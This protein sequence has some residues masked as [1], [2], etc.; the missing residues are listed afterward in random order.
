MT[1]RLKWRGSLLVPTALVSVALSAQIAEAQ[2]SGWGL[3]PSNSSLADDAAT[4]PE[5][6][7]GYAYGIDAGV[8]ETD[9][10]ALSPTNKVSQTIAIT[11]ADFNVDHR[12]RLFDVNAI[13]NFSYLEYLQHAYGNQL[14]G[15]FDGNADAAIVPGRLIW[16]LRDDFGQS[17]LDPYTPTTP[18]NVENINYVTTGPDLKVRFGGINFIDVSARYARAQY[19]TSPFNSNRLLGSVAL[20]RE[21][22]AGGSVSL[23]A[24]TERVMF[25]NTE[26][27]SDFERSSGFGRY[28]VHGTRTNFIGELGGT[29]VSQTS[30]L[31]LVPSNFVPGSNVTLAP[32]PITAANQSAGS[33]SLSGPMAKVELSRM[34]S[35]SAKVIFTAGR[36]LTD[37]SSSFSNQSTG[38]TGINSIS[39]AALTS[40]SYRVTYASAS[41]QFHRNRT[42]LAITGRWEKDIYPGLPN[43]D[44]TF[45]SVDFRVERRVTRALT[46]QFFGSYRKTDYP[47][48]ALASQLEGSTEYANGILG[49]ALTWR[50]GRGLEVRLRF[51]H[52][53]YSVSNG[54][55][56]YHETRAF[57]TVGYRPAQAADNL[58]EP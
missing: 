29:V 28:E 20:G 41:W 1:I 7:Q 15:R 49:A 54:N 37:A 45:P 10:V 26:V 17:A 6:V 30:A 16:V 36:D 40:D 34:T 19:Q 3:N 50:H 27:N 18:T 33:G 39:S 44:V 13:G 57:L 8:G 55:T 14:L 12:S 42:T 9:N 32:Q 11:D 35:A 58:L 56:G 25:D 2:V 43:L 52:D 53:S 23:N 4:T 38:L 22:S 48:A 24:N 31:A 47:R 5:R 46:A 21:V 51:D